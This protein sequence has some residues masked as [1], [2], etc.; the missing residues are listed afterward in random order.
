MYI[1]Y[2]ML[3]NWK[4]KKTQENYKK[5]V[6]SPFFLL[7]GFIA[8]NNFK[9]G[10]GGWNKYNS[11]LLEAYETFL[12]LAKD[13]HTS[14][15]SFGFFDKWLLL[16]AWFWHF[17]LKKILAVLMLQKDALLFTDGNNFNRKFSAGVKGYWR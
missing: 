1:R 16:E 3:V 10:G 6:L 13:N 14:K 17:F 7:K 9:W 4:D 2:N 5:F 12:P 11:K 8:L 15:E